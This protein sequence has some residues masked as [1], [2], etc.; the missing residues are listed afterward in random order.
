MAY[1][2]IVIS[3]GHGK[4]V[5]GAS[6]ILDEVDEARRVV[7]RLA[8]HLE[9]SG[10]DVEVFHDNT[11]QSQSENLATIVAAHNACDRDLDISV[12]FNAYEQVEKP[13]GVEVLYVTQQQ[14][15][16]QV[17]AAIASCGFIDRGA[18][19][20]TDLAFLNGTDAPAILIETCFVD[21]EADAEIYERNFNAICEAIAGALA[22]E[23]A[24][25]PPPDC[26]TGTC[27]MF[28]GPD[29]NGVAPDEGL[30]FIYEIDEENQ[31]LFLPFQPEDTTGL[32]RR[33]NPAV[34]YCAMRFDYAEHPKSTLLQ[35]VVLV[36]NPRTGFA[37]TCTPADWGPHGDTDR[38]IDL[39]P[40]MMLDLEL[41]T[42]DE[43][44]VIFPYEA[45]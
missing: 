42:D 19:K 15:A 11:S 44:E 3:S 30:A 24:V 20:R 22:G 16:G 27:S 5:R 8:E 12:H 17:S 18:K 4:Y 25:A 1:D 7:E 35:K 23:G 34:H 6:G 31:F 40:S 29:D 38:L 37:L 39:S 41:E 45:T 13:M 14:L 28:G 33:L 2:R 26:L 36:R 9:T 32:A 43:V 10:V 21:S